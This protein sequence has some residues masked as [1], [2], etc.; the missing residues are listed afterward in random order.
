MG[1]FTLALGGLAAAVGIRA[2]NGPSASERLPRAE[3]PAQAQ[4]IDQKAF[5]VLPYVPP[6]TVFNASS[7]F[8]PPGYTKES[9]EEKPFHIYDEEFYDV[10]GPNPTLTLIAHD[11]SNPLYHEATLW[12]PP[13]DEM[14]FAQNAG[15]TAAGTGL[16]KSA[17]IMKISL[18][19]AAAV[20][21]QRNATGKVNVVTVDSNPMV[22]N[23][24]GAFNYK[25]Q[26]LWASEGQG[27]DIAPGLVVMNP[28]EPYNTTM[29]LNNYFGRQFNS[30]N[31]I[32]INPRNNEIYFTDPL[33]GYLQDFRPAPALR[34]QVYRYND[35]T[36]AVTVVADDFTEPNGITF[37]PDGMYA[38]VADTG[39]NQG[40]FGKNYSNPAS[41]Y[42][43]DVKDDGTFDNRKVFAFIDSSAPDGIHCDSKGN[44]YAG[45]GD[46][47]HV[48]NPQGT[49]IGKIYLGESSA[50]FNFAGDGRMVI[51]AE[52]DLYY[53]TLAASGGA[54]IQQ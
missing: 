1:M 28:R 48:W 2:Y 25:D 50:N 4:F 10:L 9:L 31:D 33:Y 51:C 20:S 24:N 26:I 19:E 42:R 37:S 11:D 5:N 54:Y 22:I 39:I 29:L 12:Y 7:Y 6:S 34:N 53:A 45:C 13:T 35:V 41:I 30:L 38:Y 16:N 15:A 40:F 18:S 23:P 32:Y 52:T 47:V 27:A 8:V 3:I 17:I 36:G 46:G 21:S 43:F 49:L 44:V 14:F